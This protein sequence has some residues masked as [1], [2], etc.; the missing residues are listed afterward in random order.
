LEQG[1]TVKHAAILV[2]L[3]IALVACDGEQRR[4]QE[5][6]DLL[7]QERDSLTQ[8]VEERQTV[9]RETSDKV[10]SLNHD[11]ATYN[12][13]MQSFITGH[14]VAASCIRTSRS[15]WGENNAFSHDVAMTTRLGAALCSVALLNKQFADEVT[16]V[17]DQL[18]EADAH[19]RTLKEQIAVAQKELATNR[20]ELEKSEAAVRELGA[21]IADVRQQMGQ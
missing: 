1:E 14:R 8:R 16:H 21:E 12:A 20:A 6:R 7:E 18:G 17:A 13:N 3:S 9:V 15:T 5:K 10:D 2:I 19:L 11:L 4:L